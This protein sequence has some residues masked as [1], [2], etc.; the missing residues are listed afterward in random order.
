MLG[1]RQ[2]SAG[3]V[4]KTFSDP[5]LRPGLRATCPGRGGSPQKLSARRVSRSAVELS[6]TF[7]YLDSVSVEQEDLFDRALVFHL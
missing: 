4:N 7:L 3:Q 5:L 6:C 2:D 1:V